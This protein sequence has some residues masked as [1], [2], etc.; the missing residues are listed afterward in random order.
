M[1]VAIA[2][3]QRCRL[4]LSV[5]R[6]LLCCDHAAEKQTEHDRETVLH[7]RYLQTIDVISFSEEKTRSAKN[8]RFA[9]RFACR[10]IHIWP[11]NAHLATGLHSRCRNCWSGAG[12]KLCHPM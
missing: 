8:F 6:M 11:A 4:R 3:H 1:Q 2:P 12:Q 10:W 9:T 5:C 7:C